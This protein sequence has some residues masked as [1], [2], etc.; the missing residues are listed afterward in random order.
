[1]NEHKALKIAVD[2][3]T[4]LSSDNGKILGAA[5]KADF[6]LTMGLPKVGL[7]INDGPRVSGI[8][9]V[10]DI[11]YPNALSNSESVKKI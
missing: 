6:T 2:I 3:P 9:E 10:V 11:S 8:L 1:M 5:F 7:L 4:G